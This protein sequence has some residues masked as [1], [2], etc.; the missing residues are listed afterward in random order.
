M[1]LHLN[2]NIAPVSEIFFSYQGEGIFAGI[3]QIFVRFVGCNLKCNYCDTKYSDKINQK[4][5]FLTTEDVY[6][7]IVKI[8]SKNKNKFFGRKPSVSFTGGEP[9]LYCNFLETVVKKLKK[10]N[11][12]IYI[13]TNGI[14]FKEIKQLYKYCDIIAADVKLKSACSK[15]LLNLHEQ[16]LKNSKN[17]VFTKIVITK[18]VS[19]KEFTEA[20]L[21]VSKISKN[22]KL[23]LQPS[24]FSKKTNIKLIK[25][26]NIAAK[27]LKDVRI[28]PQ[29]HKIW[30]IK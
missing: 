10:E 11:F 30:S 15:N 7:S 14:L 1:T 2:K 28:L 3:G 9:L 8:Y 22:I 18:N 12:E 19:E 23:V 26:Y 5:K 27:Y 29:M 16:F 21:T 13:E 25:C 6:K 24:D 4:T 17:K 20:V